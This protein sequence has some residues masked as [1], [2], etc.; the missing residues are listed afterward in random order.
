MQQTQLT[1][2][3]AGVNAH[4][5]PSETY[6]PQTMPRLLGQ[7]D[8]IALST[9]ALF[10]IS[11]VT[12]VVIGGAAGFTYWIIGIVF[13]FLPCTLICAQ[14]SKVYDHE[15]SIYNW[16]TRALGPFWGF[17]VGLCTW[18]PGIVSVV[19]AVDVIMS[20]LQ[21]LHQNWLTQPWQQG[22]LIIG[23]ILIVG[24]ISSQNVK[25]IQYLVNSVFFSTSLL[26]GL[27]VLATVVWL[28]KGHPSATN[29]STLSGWLPQGGGPETNNFALLGTVTLALLGT[30][31][32]LTMLNEVKEKASM[33]RALLWGAA[34]VIVAY[35]VCTIGLLVVQGPSAALNAPNAVVLV[36]STV[37]SS[38]GPVAG[39]IAY[40]CL[41]LF[42]FVVAVVYNCAYARLLLVASIDRQLPLRLAKLGRSRTPLTAIW[43]G[44]LFAIIIVAVIFFVVPLFTAFGNPQVLNSDAYLITAAGLLLVWAFSFLFPFIDFCVLYRRSPLSFQGRLLL[45]LPIL[46]LCCIA[47]PVVCLL[48]IVDTIA[49]SFAPALIAN[50]QWTIFV[51]T[52]MVGSLFICGM[53]SMVASAQATFEHFGN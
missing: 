14:L 50:G 11:N 17:F 39:T 46:L 9:L 10:W 19:S 8:M 13:F 25:T 44:T 45:P 7:F 49:N 2:R 53:A 20:C 43:V 37:T 36:M 42:F 24:L 23:I 16:T 30:T 3:P 38:L 15:G 1:Q 35:I 12:G 41:M 5:L 34:L 18:L 48:T 26:V 6:V 51:L 52:F 47:G 4:T 31:G 40:V 27:V 32:P 28:L 21:T 29:F 33:T 22:L